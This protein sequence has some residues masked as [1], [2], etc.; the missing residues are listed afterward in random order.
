MEFFQNSDEA[1]PAN[2]DLS[3]LEYA[4]L[5]NLGCESEFA[6]LDVRIMAS[7]GSTI[8]QTHSRKNIVTTNRLL[9]HPFP[10]WVA[11]KNNKN[12]S[13]L[14]HRRMWPLS[15]PLRPSTYRLWKCPKNLALLKKEEHKRKKTQ[16]TMKLLDTCEIMDQWHRN[17]SSWLIHSKRRNWSLRLV[18]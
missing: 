1:G 10:S 15:R 4:P 7:G 17:P 14:E 18:I 2:S 16:R 5:T 6:K 8:V 13:G 12:G 3:K 11:L 9:I